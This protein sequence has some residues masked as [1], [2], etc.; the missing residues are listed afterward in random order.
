MISDLPL[1]IS[2]LHK[3]LLAHKYSAVDLVDTY[4]SRINAFDKNINSFIT[5]TDDLAYSQAKIADRLISDLGKDA[6]KEYPLLGVVVAYKDLF[7]IDGVR[8][9]AGSKVLENYTAQYSAT[10]VKRMQKAGAICIGKTNLDAWGHG[11]SG[12]NSDFGPTKNPWNLEYVPGGSSSGSAAAVAANFALASTGTD[13]GSSVRLPASFCNLVGLKPTYGA[14]SRWGVIAFA[15]S[16]DTIGQ[17][18]HTVSD[19][20]KIFEIWKGSDDKDVNANY[21]KNAVPTK[22]KFTI[23]LPKEYFDDGVCSE[24]LANLEEV[25][26][27]YQ[28]QNIKFKQISLPHTEY[29]TAVYY[30]T[31]FAEAS[32]NLA[33]YDGVRFGNTR[34]SFGPEAK[35][36][37]MLGSYVLSAGYR[38]QYYVKAMKVRSKIIEDFK[39]AFTEVDAIL[40]PVSPTPAFKLG[41]K[42]DDPLSMYLSD[43]FTVNA[44][45]AG[46]PGLSIP[47]GFS[48][49]GLPIGY[50]LM[51][52]KFSESTLYKLGKI[53]QSN[54]DYHLK[55]AIL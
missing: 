48:K 24:V 17:M 11:S 43:I 40:A 26:K 5:V 53:Y 7:N 29:G 25:K 49:S 18:T 22:N 45:I 50:Q 14:V 35:R 15:S 27:V 39:K 1:S 10:S 52:P 54:T 21:L 12:E 23:G 51:G 47:S 6:F 28:K 42:T 55:K 19:N 37:I 32:S 36:R 44:N 3:N 16:L 4:L 13:T 30:I 2:G 46:V 31:A 8:T 38:D 9:T 33:R 41:Q 20:E 34:A